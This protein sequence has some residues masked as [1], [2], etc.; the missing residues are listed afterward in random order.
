MKDDAAEVVYDSLFHPCRG[1]GR[2]GKAAP[3]SCQV[4]GVPL[5]LRCRFGDRHLL[6]CPLPFWR[7]DDH[8]VAT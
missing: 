4:C 7:E 1:C 6:H 5:C 8:Q 2:Q 3:I